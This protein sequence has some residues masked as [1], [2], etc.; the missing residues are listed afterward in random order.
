MADAAGSAERHRRPVT[1]GIAPTG[2]APHPELASQGS[3]PTEEIT[4][5]HALVT[6]H[7]MTQARAAAIAEADELRERQAHARSRSRRRR[8]RRIRVATLTRR[9]RVAAPAR[10]ARA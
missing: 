3:V 8:A 9:I 1:D 5:R 6:T 10:R 4:M 2:P 7:L